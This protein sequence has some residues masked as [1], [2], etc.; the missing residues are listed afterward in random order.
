MFE[1]VENPARCPVR[2]YHLYESKRPK[3]CN[4]AFFLTVNYRHKSDKVWYSDMPMGPTRIGEIMGRIATRGGLVGHYTNHSVRRTMCTQ[5]YQKGVNP[6]LIA[7]LSGHK[8]INSLSRYTTTSFQQQRDMC[9]LLQGK[10][11]SST[12]TASLS[13]PSTSNTAGIR[14]REPAEIEEEPDSS[15]PHSQYMTMTLSRQQKTQ[16]I[17]HGALAGVTF[18]GPVTINFGSIDQ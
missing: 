10:K 5:L 3:D 13:A 14:A 9:G 2:L 16:S 12:T 8:N 1:N 18:H 6:I 4:N 15:L 17:V 7:Q 11:P